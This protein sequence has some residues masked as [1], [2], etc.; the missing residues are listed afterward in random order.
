MQQGVA[1]LGEQDI[2]LEHRL[3]SMSIRNVIAARLIKGQIEWT[4]TGKAAIEENIRR[5]AE[6]LVSS[7]S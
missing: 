1:S 5:A 3:R 7:L 6:D 4:E 2:T